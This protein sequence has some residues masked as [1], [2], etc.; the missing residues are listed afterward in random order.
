M[1]DQKDFEVCFY[2]GKDVSTQ[3]K[4][5]S[6]IS[7]LGL[8]NCLVH[9]DA[10]KVNPQN[11]IICTLDRHFEQLKKEGAFSLKCDKIERTKRPVESVPFSNPLK[12]FHHKSLTHS[13]FWL[14]NKFAKVGLSRKDIQR[15]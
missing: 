4:L 3:A 11:T 12:K 7:Q 2:A 6:L 1:T 5:K 15:L 14:A 10:K 13:L 9:S 8:I